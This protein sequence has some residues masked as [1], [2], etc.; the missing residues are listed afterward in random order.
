MKKEWSAPAL[1]VLDV[2]QTKFGTGTTRTD[3]VTT[4][5]FDVTDS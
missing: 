4:D 5:D 2:E 3:M 1:E